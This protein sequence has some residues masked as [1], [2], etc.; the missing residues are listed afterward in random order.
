MAA[1]QEAG[2]GVRGEKGIAHPEEHRL[3]QQAMRLGNIDQQRR[4]A[5]QLAVLAPQ[6]AVPVALPLVALEVLKGAVAEAVHAPDGRH[7]GRDGDKHGGRN[8]Q[9]VARQQASLHSARADEQEQHSDRRDDDGVLT[10]FFQAPGLKPQ[11]G[12]A[13]VRALLRRDAVDN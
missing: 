2:A 8:A 5:L 10:Y 9:R 6:P 11:A 7:H 1:R 4:R 13:G 3:R 12:S